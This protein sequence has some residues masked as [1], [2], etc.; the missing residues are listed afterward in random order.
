M[1]KMSTGGLQHHP[2]NDQVPAATSSASHN[3]T[4]PEFHHPKHSQPQQQF[5]LTG[6]FLPSNFRTQS[7]QIAK[8]TIH[9]ICRH[10]NCIPPPN[11]TAVIMR[12]LL[13][14]TLKNRLEM[15]RNLV[16]TLDIQQRDQLELLHS[17]AT[18]MF[19]D[20]LVN[21]GRIVTFHAFCGYLA[22]YCEERHIPDCGDL[23]AEILANIV[24]NRLGLWIVANGGWVCNHLHPIG[25][26]LCSVQRAK[27]KLR[28]MRMFYD[29]LF[30]LKKNHLC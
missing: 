13:D 6:D 9:Y 26:H 23:I 22:R 21:W 11:R 30:G 4:V 19:D 17:I 15:M 14:D 25:F 18:N 5:V 29:T 10:E 12:N 20:Q 24:V 16:M 8:D 1:G 3:N 2:G 28:I 27:A 7:V